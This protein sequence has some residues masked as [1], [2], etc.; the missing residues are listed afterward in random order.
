LAKRK[1]DNAKELYEEQFSSTTDLIQAESEYQRAEY[2]YSRSANI[3]SVY[4]INE[5]EGVYS[6]KAP[7]SGYVVEKNIN[8][9]NS[10]RSDDGTS[11]F[12]ISNLKKVWV[13]INIY[14][15]DINEV[16]EGMKVEVKTLANPG[17]VFE[18]TIDKI[19]QVLDNESRVLHA[20]VELDNN[21]AAL[22]PGMFASIILRKYI[23][24]ADLAVPLK[25]LVFDNNNYFI[26]TYEN[27]KYRTHKVE[28]V[29]TNSDYAFIKTDVPAGSI[30]IS[31]GSLLLYNE[32]N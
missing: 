19:N 30:V 4:G 27:N 31:E 11:L 16:K 15:T 24:K 17:R 3:A 22:K 32:L 23:D 8:P 2:E 25:S 20:R 6:I 9:N 10:I 26:I 21:D 28:V 14:E 13:M 12:T 29:S 7:E 5:N 1:L 18:G